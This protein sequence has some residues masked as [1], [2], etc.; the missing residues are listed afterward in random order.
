MPTLFSA[1]WGRDLSSH[2]FQYDLWLCEYFIFINWKIFLISWLFRQSS[3]IFLRFIHTRLLKSLSWTIRIS[4]INRTSHF[5]SYEISNDCKYLRDDSEE[6]MHSWIFFDF[7]LSVICV[8]YKVKKLSTILK[9]MMHLFSEK[10]RDRTKEKYE[11]HIY[12]LIRV[13]MT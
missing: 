4:L 7:Y 11:R 13:F 2:T 10:Y 6:N 5:I 3:A 12:L 1:S 9:C 8:P